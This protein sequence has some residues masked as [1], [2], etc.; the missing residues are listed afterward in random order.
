ME[1]RK[2][3]AAVVEKATATLTQKGWVYIAGEMRTGKT[4]MALETVGRTLQA[5]GRRGPILCV[6]KVSAMSSVQKDIVTLGLAGRCHLINYE[7]L[8]K[9]PKL[10]WDAV[11][12]DEAHSLGGYPKPSLCQKRLKAIMDGL[13]RPP[14]YVMLSG[15]P[16]PETFSQIYHQLQVSKYTP[17]TQ[18]NF[19]SWAKHWVDIREIRISPVRTAKDYSRCNPELI[20]KLQ[21][22]GYIIPLT[23]KEAGFTHSEV[24]ETIIRLPLNGAL[25]AVIAQLKK[26]R[27][28]Y[29]GDYSIVADTAASVRM[30]LHQLYSGTVKTEQGKALVLDTTK[31]DYIKEHYSDRKV[32]VFY[33][34]V[35]EGDLLRRTLTNIHQTPEAF[36]KAASGVFLCQIQAGSQGVNLSTA[37]CLVFYNI[38]FSFVQY[39]QARARASH[40]DRQT[41]SQL[42]W[43][44]TEGGIEEKILAVV[45]QKKSYTNKY[46]YKDYPDDSRAEDT[47]QHTAPLQ[48]AARHLHS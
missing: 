9:A 2:E 14:L 15:T 29:L 8:H 26:Y 16:T 6:T 33:Q 47:G 27:V 17:F 40:Y 25:A 36:N 38:N 10:Q 5:T 41:P 21:Q 24:E 1:L 13:Q 18:T 42:H 30:K 34:F 46:Y 32:A 45:K 37:D 12:A 3:Q 22:A 4:F 19:Y 20:A 28:V 44:F 31:A 39:W 43:I 11:I 23:Q 48:A 7:S 35:A